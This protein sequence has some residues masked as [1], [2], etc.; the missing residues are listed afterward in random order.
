MEEQR[1][2]A[3]ILVYEGKAFRHSYILKKAEF[4]SRRCKQLEQLLV[5]LRRQV[6]RW[7]SGEAE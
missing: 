5:V 6:R 2:M 4:S 3:D 1:L 7:G